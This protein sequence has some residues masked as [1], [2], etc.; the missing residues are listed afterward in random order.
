MF[1]IGWAG[2]LQLRVVAKYNHAPPP[3]VSDWNESEMVLAC[4]LSALWLRPKYCDDC[5]ELF[6]AV[7]SLEMEEENQLWFK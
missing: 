3:H 6:K 2:I 5:Y 7:N 1:E 4:C